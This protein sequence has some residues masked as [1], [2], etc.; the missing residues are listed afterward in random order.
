MKIQHQSMVVRE[1]R[2]SLSPVGPPGARLSL[3]KHPLHVVV[4]LRRANQS[5]QLDMQSYVQIIHD[6][7]HLNKSVCLAKNFHLLNK[8]GIESSKRK[9]F[10]DIWPVGL[11]L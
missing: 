10:V 6:A 8:D 9:V 2:Y 4:E 1:A 3:S 5:K 7:L 11:V